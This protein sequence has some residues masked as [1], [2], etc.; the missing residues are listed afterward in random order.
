MQN[1][2]DWQQVQEIFEQ[3]LRVAASDRVEFVQQA[4]ASDEIVLEVLSLLDAYDEAEDELE[5]SPLI[6]SATQV[7]EQTAQP[8]DV[9]CVEGYEIQNEIHRGGQGAVYRAVQASTKRVVALKFMHSGAEAKESIKKRFEREVELAGSLRHPGIVRVFDS[10]L[11]SGQYYYV[12]DYIDGLCLDDYVLAEKLPIRDIAALFIPICE[13]VNYAHQRGVIHRDLKPS[14]VLVDREGHC[15][16]VDFGL[17]KLG[18]DDTSD[19]QKLSLTGQVMGTLHYMSPEQARGESD[20]V[21]TRSD[22][23]SLGVMLYELLTG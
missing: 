16:I 12:M 10:G 21:D 8:N 19:T 2:N 6:D 3:A 9:H 17:A 23:Y 4:A 7:M 22:V 5:I 11:T 1:P 15:H 18:N 20:A 14:N 13:A